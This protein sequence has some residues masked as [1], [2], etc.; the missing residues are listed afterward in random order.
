MDKVPCAIHIH[1]VRAAYAGGVW[2]FGP[3]GRIAAEMGGLDDDCEEQA[4]PTLVVRIQSTF[5]GAFFYSRGSSVQYSRQRQI[6]EGPFALVAGF[7][8]A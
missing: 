4:W 7:H 3:S 5:S 8:A 1:G 6:L 2:V